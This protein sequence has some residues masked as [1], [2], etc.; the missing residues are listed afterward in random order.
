MDYKSEVRHVAGRSKPLIQ[1]R[2]IVRDF[3]KEEVL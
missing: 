1:N 2:L 3:K